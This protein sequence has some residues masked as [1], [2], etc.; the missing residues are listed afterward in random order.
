MKEIL[1]GGL[2]WATA[3]LV[4]WSDDFNLVSDLGCLRVCLGGTSAVLRMEHKA[5]LTFGSTS[6]QRAAATE[7]LKSRKCLFIYLLV[8]TS[9]GQ[10]RTPGGHLPCCCP[11]VFLQTLVF[12]ATKHHISVGTLDLASWTVKTDGPQQSNPLILNK[13]SNK[14]LVS[15]H[16]VKAPVLE[17]HNFLCR[18]RLMSRLEGYF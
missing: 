12:E 9:S 15:L 11:L 2:R 16:K 8:L 4:L 1:A 13:Y 10:I 6:S 17:L 14:W 7:K 5:G 3:K 18:P